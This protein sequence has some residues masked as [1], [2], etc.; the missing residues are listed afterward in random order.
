VSFNQ[1]TWKSAFVLA[2]VMEEEILRDR[3]LLALGIGGALGRNGV[4]RS[5]PSAR[6]GKVRGLP[7]HVPAPQTKATAHR[8]C[9]VALASVTP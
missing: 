8:F 6:L 5:R 3:K 4:S 9:V 1:E 2:I 7:P